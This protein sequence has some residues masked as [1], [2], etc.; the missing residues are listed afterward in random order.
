M[1]I[2]TLLSD[3]QLRLKMGLG[4]RQKVEADYAKSKNMQAY[5]DPI[6]HLSPRNPSPRRA[7]NSW[8][9]QLLVTNNLLGQPLEYSRARG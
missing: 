7:Q 3:P 8:L 6:R 2:D 9:A 4:G 1:A 5:R